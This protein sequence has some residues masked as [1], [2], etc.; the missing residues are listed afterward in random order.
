MG[1][2]VSCSRFLPQTSSSPCR[3]A[4][5]LAASCVALTWT[6]M[7]R[8]SC[9]WLEPP[10]SMA[11]RE[12]AGCLS[13]REKRW[14]PGQC[15]EDVGERDSRAFSGLSHSESLSLPDPVLIRPLEQRQT[16]ANMQ[17]WV[18]M[19]ARP[20]AKLFIYRIPRLILVITFWDT[21]S[22]I[23]QMGTSQ[24][25]KAGQLSKGTKSHR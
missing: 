23:L 22:F 9:C 1:R 25:S 11:S 4:L 21:M 18:K 13:T 17:R 15:V 3:L 8:Q 6:K 10:C 7:G 2:E 16:I 12:E 5:I 19:C 24:L 20:S 14:G